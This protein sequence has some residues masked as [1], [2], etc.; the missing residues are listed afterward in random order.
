[1]GEEEGGVAKRTRLVSVNLSNLES[2]LLGEVRLGSV[3]LLV[4]V[5]VPEPPGH[6][7]EDL[8][9]EAAAAADETG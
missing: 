7:D 6:D 5:N 1:V 3:L 4:L 8:E 9:S 2:L